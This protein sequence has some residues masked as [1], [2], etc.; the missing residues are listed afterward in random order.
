MNG[1]RWLTDGVYT[2]G[3]VLRVILKAILLFIIINILW[4][5]FQPFPWLARLQLYNHLLPGRARLPYAENIDAANSVSATDLNTLL[6]SHELADAYPADE[7]RVLLVGDSSVWGYLLKPDETLSAAL[8]QM[9]LTTSDGRP[10]RFYNLGYP[11]MTLA[12]DLLLLDAASA[13]DV[14]AVVWLVTL[15][16]FDRSM[17]YEHG[18]VEANLP[19]LAELWRVGES[20][21]IK[22]YGLELTLLRQRQL[23]ADWLRLQ[24]VAFPWAATGID[25]IYPDVYTPRQEDF[26][27]NVRWDGL[28]P[29]RGFDSERLL[30]DLFRGVMDRMGDIP[31]LLVNEP[32]FISQGL[33]SDLHYNFFYPRWAYD[34]YRQEM[35]ALTTA[36]GWDYLDVWDQIDADSFTDSAIHMT[37]EGTRQLAELLVP[38][39]LTLATG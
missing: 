20:M 14:D 32:I 9:A 18:V 37:P 8:N 15:E 27:E 26:D 29:D 13:F 16:S 24:L 36:E 1:W 6:Y 21:V 31:V 38:S 25:Q 35:T 39:I 4:A 11:G 34:A 17:I 5:V 2:P 23:V 3:F 22:S 7:F 33:N 28:D 12:K 30:P 10:M 19:R